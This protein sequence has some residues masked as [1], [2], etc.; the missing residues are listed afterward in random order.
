MNIELYLALEN[1]LLILTMM[2]FKYYKITIL[3]S[4][5]ACEQLLSSEEQEALK[6]RKCFVF[7]DRVV[8]KSNSL[9]K[10][11]VIKVEK[12]KEQEETGK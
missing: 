6:K 9:I 3:L 12:I 7:R 5:S 10:P 1:E 8:R 2:G 4:K 11:Y